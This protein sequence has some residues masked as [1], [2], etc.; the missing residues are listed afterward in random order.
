MILYHCNMG[1]P[2]LNKGSIVKIPNNGVTP[3]NAHA[4]ESIEKALIMDKPQPD[5]EECCYYYDTKE[6]GGISRAG[7]IQR[8]NR[9]GRCFEI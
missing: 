1:Y 4:A 5:Y 8:G 9:K 7:Y 6:N 2:L 3:R